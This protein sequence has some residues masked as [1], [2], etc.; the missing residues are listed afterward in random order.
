MFCPNCGTQITEGAKFCP[1]C[2]TQAGEAL[3]GAPVQQA[4]PSYQN[5]A[6]QPV[7]QQTPQQLSSEE[8]ITYE[9]NG[10]IVSTSR[11]VANGKTYS[12]SNIS[13]V[14]AK[15]V[16]N[17]ASKWPM[18]C[19]IS[20]LLC[21]AP[22]IIEGEIS[23]LGQD[24]TTSVILGSV[25]FIVLCIV[26]SKDPCGIYSVCISSNSGETDALSSTDSAYIYSVV[27]AINDAIVKRGNQRG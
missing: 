1:N 27:N 7:Y 8:I 23:F 18:I 11:F 19:F 5:A 6:P 2:G 15:Y 17:K 13:S 26:G 22:G 21:F 20:I 4:A 10:V 12:M 9:G 24:R 16:K 3:T 25:S 14:E